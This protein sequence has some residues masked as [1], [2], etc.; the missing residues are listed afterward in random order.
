MIVTLHAEKKEGGGNRGVALVGAVHGVTLVGA[1]ALATVFVLANVS[2]LVN[3]LF[4]PSSFHPNLNEVVQQ[5][6]PSYNPRGTS[7]CWSEH[8]PR[9]VGQ[10]PSPNSS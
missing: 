10:S 6:R 7:P 5:A 3:I 4:L 9:R 2:A 8:Q 1:V